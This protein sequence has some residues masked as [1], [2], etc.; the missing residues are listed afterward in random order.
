[1]QEKEDPSCRWFKHPEDK[2]QTH[3]HTNEGAHE[4]EDEDAVAK[5]IYSLNIGI[6]LTKTCN[7]SSEDIERH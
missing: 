7:E 5:D 4:E 2:N 3:E 1:M 6:S